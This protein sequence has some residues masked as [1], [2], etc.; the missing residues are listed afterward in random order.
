VG[1]R[2]M[3]MACPNCGDDEQLVVEYLGWAHIRYD[4]EADGIEHEDAG[5][6]DGPWRWDDDSNIVCWACEWEGKARDTQVQET[7]S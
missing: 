6:N 3:G 7:E 1:M 4:N 5:T 2:L